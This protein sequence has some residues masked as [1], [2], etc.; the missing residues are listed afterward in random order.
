MRSLGYG[1]IEQRPVRIFDGESGDFC[2][3]RHASWSAYYEA[4]PR[5]PSNVEPAPWVKARYSRRVRESRKS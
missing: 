2:P 4:N 5:N 1:G 3:R